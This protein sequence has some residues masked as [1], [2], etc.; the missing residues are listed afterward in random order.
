M[1]PAPRLILRAVPRTLHNSIII[2]SLKAPTTTTLFALGLLALLAVSPCLAEPLPKQP[3]ADSPDPMLP[4]GGPRALLGS[5]HHGGGHNQHHNHQLH[6]GGV[7]P[8]W[9]CWYN[10]LRYQPYSSL[11]AYYC[12]HGGN[13]YSHSC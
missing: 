4:G 12:C 2:M 3:G 1:L 6:H 8:G 7:H 10:S 13:W 5:K 9:Y 11:N